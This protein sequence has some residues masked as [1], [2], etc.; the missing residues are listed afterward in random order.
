MGTNRDRQKWFENLNIG[1]V[2]L[3][4]GVLMVISYLIVPIIMNLMYSGGM[5]NDHS[6]HIGDTVGGTFGPFVGGIGVVLTFLAFWVQYQANQQQKRDLQIERFESRLF[7]MLETHRNNVA[8]IKVQFQFLVVIPEAKGNGSRAGNNA[9]SKQEGHYELQTHSY[10]GRAAFVAMSGYLRELFKFLEGKRNDF[11]KSGK[12]VTDDKVLYEIVY[13][14]FFSGCSDWTVTVGKRFKTIGENSFLKEAVDAIK[15]E[16]R[17]RDRAPY[18]FLGARIPENSLSDATLKA[19]THSALNPKYPFGFDHAA[20]LSHYFRHLFMMIEYV[21]KQDFLD[22]DQKYEYVRQIRAQL[23]NHEQLLIF[24]NA[25][26]VFGRPWMD[27]GYLKDYCL[28]RSMS[29]YADFY[30]DPVTVIG[31][32]NRHGKWNFDLLEIQIRDGES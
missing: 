31:E 22:Y 8:E 29:P 4:G 18:D 24:Y 12:K 32:K 19:D 26:S 21:H 7:S 9:D 27:L 13:L 17:A 3:F 2:L 30:V 23:S 14:I 16:A 20:W 11:D 6:G 25:L 1:N 10:E 5:Y 15:T 28:L